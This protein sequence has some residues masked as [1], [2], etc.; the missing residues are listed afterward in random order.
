[1]S[2]AI[3]LLGMLG[4]IAALNCDLEPPHAGPLALA[5]LL[6]AAGLVW[7]EQRRPTKILLIPQGPR[8]APLDGLVLDT[9][10]LQERGPLAVL[11]W[12]AGKQRGALL[13][14]PDTLPRACRRELRL[15]VR[16]HTISRNAE[17]VAP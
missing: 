16:D 15:A 13:F 5:A 14:W 11:R 3:I 10:Q 9:L 2:G 4:A 17:T 8:P 7:R 6:W 12:Q 1:L